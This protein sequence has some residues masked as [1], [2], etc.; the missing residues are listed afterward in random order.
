MFGTYSRLRLHVSASDTEVVRAA[1][2]MLDMR[3]CLGTRKLRQARRRFYRQM[4][5]FHHDNQ[6]MFRRYRF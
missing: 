4:L 5:K 1:R 2:R 3:K 6:A